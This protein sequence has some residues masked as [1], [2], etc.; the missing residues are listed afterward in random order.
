MQVPYLERYEILQTLGQG[1]MGVVYLAR[2]K[3]LDRLVAIKAI[4]PYLA[5][6]PEVRERFAAEASVL[7]R[8]SHPNIVT[9]YDYIEEPDAL[10]LVMEYV[11]GK[12][13]SEIL[14]AGPLPLES[15][16]KYFTQILDAFA[17][18]HSKGVIH[19]DIKPSNILITSHGQVKILDFGVAKILSSDHSQTRTGMRLGTLMYMSPEQVK[20]EK[21]IDARSDIYSLGVVLF[22]M[23][24]GKPPYDPELGEFEI[25]LRIVRE[26]LFDLSHPPANIPQKILEVILH[27][28]EKN[29]EHRFSSCAEFREAFEGAFQEGISSPIP[30]TEV[31]PALPA[32]TSKDRKKFW[33]KIGGGIAV[34]ILG[35]IV[36][37]TFGGERRA[38]KGAA[39]LADS[40]GADTSSVASDV[41]A[42]RTD[43][44]T[45]P[46]GASDSGLSERSSQKASTNPGT[47]HTSP[48]PSPTPPVTS[49]PRNSSPSKQSASAP[50]PP[51]PADTSPQAH[52]LTHTPSF[53]EALKVEVQNFK[54]YGILQVKADLILTNSSHR[55]WKNIQ[56]IVRFINKEGK[57]KRTETLQVP[58]MLP[59]G[60]WEK[61]LDYLVGGT[62]RIEAEVIAA[63]PGP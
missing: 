39:T 12:P 31:T 62:A 52:P 21:N 28:T 27:A 3:K 48:L 10:Y 41:Y 19:R 45:V 6:E 4:S 15:I 60:R 58:E 49:S 33:I 26:P 29:P 53:Q 59:Y 7:A 50:P 63:E 32:P 20:G 51:S 44:L 5:Q 16:R 24:T 55:D 25:S 8:L 54:K 46:S 37:L 2:Q 34:F 22:E 38:S 23:L 1:G 14:K 9:L 13:L 30:P 57:V 18:A 47:P 43:T 35:G 56:I 17:Y 61:K 42:L 36:L 40:L 11:E